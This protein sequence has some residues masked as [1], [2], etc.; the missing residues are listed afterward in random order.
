MAKFTMTRYQLFLFSSQTL[1]QSYQFSLFAFFVVF[2]G[3]RVETNVL[4][5]AL[6]FWE[7]LVLFDK[8]NYG[9]VKSFIH[10]GF[11]ATSTM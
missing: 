9:C 2:W 5:A 4:R 3:G 8:F 6:L 11:V 10:F 7:T 1:P